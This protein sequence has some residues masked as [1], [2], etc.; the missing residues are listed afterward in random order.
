MNNKYKL[1]GVVLVFAAIA[2]TVAV[3]FWPSPPSTDPQHPPM[4]IGAYYWPG[5]YWIDIAHS[6]GWFVEAGLNVEIIDANQ[7]YYG[8]VTDIHEGNL[9]T[10]TVWLFDVVKRRQMGE[11]LVMVLAT[12]ESVGSEALIGAGSVDS[13]E[14]L[15][16]GRIGVPFE[17]AMV[18]ALDEILSHFGMTLDD[19]VLVDMVPETA[20]EVL[21]A[22][23][24]DAV[25]TWE[26]YA[27]RTERTGGNRLY[28]SSQMPG[29][30]MAG[31]I[32][33]DDFIQGRHDEI[34]RMLRVWH[35]ATQYLQ[36]HQKEAYRIV[37]EVNGATTQEVADFA[38]H[39][40]IMNL[41][42]NVQA[43]TYAS[44]VESLFGSARK[45]NRYLIRK[46]SAV[47]PLI[48][49]TDLVK[50]RFVRALVREEEDL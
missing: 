16:G 39:S 4:R 22:G 9:D 7:D 46:D 17:S 28:D 23:E 15:K 36:S 49:E 35:R 21:A 45:I 37:A 24:V 8:A 1:G 32:F 5:T 34:L 14:Q 31:M 33:R 43:F 3:M 47:A 42:D 2:C 27:T 38:K 30:I 19:V 18:Y 44:G 48:E 11:K 13:V 29:L 25:M 26:P 6:K 40:H 12:D 50:G 20:S 10:L 41:Q